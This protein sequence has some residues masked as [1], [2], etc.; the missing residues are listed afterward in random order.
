MKTVLLVTIAAIA[1]AGCVGAD[2]K[3]QRE[4]EALIAS[5]LRDPDSAKFDEAAFVG[6]GGDL[7]CGHVNAKNGMGGY[8]GRSVYI[9]WKGRH[10]V[11]P[12]PLD[13]QAMAC[14]ELVAVASEAG[15]AAWTRPGFHE[16]CG[17]VSEASA[18]PFNFS[19]P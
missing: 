18:M 10:Y 3:A 1:L 8:V 11:A 4:A 2:G 13:A 6:A 14:C 12:F 17:V 15:E 19:Q 7:V 5:Q 16:S 9:V